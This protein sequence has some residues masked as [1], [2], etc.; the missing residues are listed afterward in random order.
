[1][2]TSFPEIG[3]GAEDLAVAAAPRL[4]DEQ[5]SSAVRYAR[6][7]E[8]AAGQVLFDI[9]DDSGDLVLCGSARLE[10]LCPAAAA[11]CEDVFF[12]YGPGQFAGELALLTGQRQTLTV[13]VSEA[14]T[15]HRVNARALRLL[16]QQETELS[17]LLLRTF[18]ARR[19]LLRQATEQT[20]RLV[21]DADSAAG[22]ALRTFLARQGVPYAWVEDDSIAADTI[23]AATGST[24]A[25]LPLALIGDDVMP[26][27]SPGSLSERLNL[28]YRRTG[29]ATA[30]L[31]VVGAGP[32][33]LAAA[34]YGAS[35][36]LQTV[37]LDAVATGGQAATSA[38]IENY[39]GFPFGLSGADLAAR[40]A[41]QALKFGAQIASPCPVAALETDGGAHTVTLADGTRIRARAVVL[42]TGASY[43]ALPVDRWAELTGNGIYY[44]ATDLEAQPMAGRPV[45][46][47]G[48][49]NSAGQA[50]LHLARYAADV[51][52]ALRGGDLG[53]RMSSY[54]VDRI[55]SDPR[56]TVLTR[57]EVAELHGGTRLE[58]V[59]VAERGG[60]ATRRIPCA[61][62]FCF[63]GAEPA[64]GWLTHVALDEAGFI[65]TDRA[66][67]PAVRGS[68]WRD[69]GREPLPYET[70]VPGVFAAGDVRAE[71]M[72]RVAAA[73]GD[74]ASAVRSVHQY[75]SLATHG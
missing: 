5:F 31:A 68:R 72:K 67:T 51:T 35:E 18:L 43:R 55:V 16:M 45:L 54:L 74:G 15:I 10:A 56:I 44:A 53:A 14:G 60:G 64:T 69:L 6:R 42:A 65:P 47:V 61:G 11:D 29:P 26:R 52:L 57:T 71:S 25:D 58:G 19:R 1:M 73:A 46:V 4:T 12:N 23:R 63:I 8:V 50:A 40:A 2:A 22:M 34:V 38:R 17:D 3:D 48:G 32:A 36:G 30:D 9:G 21:G 66:L 24:T 75:L 39:L 27:V 62:L 59:T 33:G 37:L 28:A 70:S 13:R 7:E 41:V 20:L 49:A